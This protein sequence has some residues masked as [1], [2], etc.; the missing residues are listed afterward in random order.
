MR[1]SAPIVDP[2]KLSWGSPPYM[3][4]AMVAQ[5]ATCNIYNHF[6]P[7]KTKTFAL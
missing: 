5:V 1:P 4:K 2:V 3:K 7:E 6:I